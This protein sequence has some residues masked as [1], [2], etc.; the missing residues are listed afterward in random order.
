MINVVR[1]TELKSSLES[2]LNLFE[3]VRMG[4]LQK[5]CRGQLPGFNAVYSLPALG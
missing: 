1:D 5:L 3:V 4:N 2:P